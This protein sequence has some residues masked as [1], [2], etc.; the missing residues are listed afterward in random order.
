MVETVHDL[1]Q[2]QVDCPILVGG[3]ALSNRFT[4]LNIAPEYGGLV[5][6]SQD[7]MSGLALANTIQ[8]ADKRATLSASLQ[9]E[10]EDMRDAENRR[11]A[12]SDNGA[13]APVAPAQVRRDVPAQR[14]PD[15]R[16]HV[17]RDYD[18]TQIFPYIN[19]QMLYVRHLGFNGRFAEA[20]E[21]GDAAAIELRE[22][23]RRVEDMVL[24]HPD[25]NANAVFQV[26]PMPVG[27]AAAVGAGA[28]WTDCNRAVLL[29]AAV[30]EGRA[31]PLGLRS[32]QDGGKF[33]RKRVG[34]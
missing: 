23:V 20:L 10:T 18:M 9:A 13:A 30:P 14:P 25:V 19:P 31:V 15:L 6:Y 26:L 1:R 32:P 11:S 16:L 17:L 29:W 28:G 21:A 12:A 8:D 4:R 27:R 7:A 2:A 3:A 33:R 24:A 34:R 5:A 22:S